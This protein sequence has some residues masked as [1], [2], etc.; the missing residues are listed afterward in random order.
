MRRLPARVARL[1]ARRLRPWLLVLASL[2]PGTPAA[3]DP[4][5]APGGGFDR[6][7]LTELQAR[8]L[9]LRLH[10]H[11]RWRALVHYERRWPLPGFTSDATFDGFYLA[12]DGRSDPRSELAATLAAFFDADAVRKDEPVQCSFPARFRWLDEELALDPGR[13]P[14]QPC[15]AYDAWRAGLGGAAISLVFPEAFMNSPASMFG[16][17]LLRVDVTPEESPRNLAAYVLDFTAATGGESGPLYLLKGLFGRYAGYFSVNPYYAKTWLYADWQNRDI[18]EYRLRLEP[19]EIDLLLMQLWELRAVTFP[20]WFLDENC[21]YRLLRLL[22]ASRPGLDLTVGFGPIVLPVDTVRAVVEEP[23]LVDR[24]HYRA[25]PATEIRSRLAGLSEAARGFARGLGRAELE[26]D[27]A[28]GA[29]LDLRERAAALSIGYD[30]LRYRF[31]AGELGEQEARSRAQRILLARSR[32]GPAP[33]GAPLFAPLAEPEVR[34]DLGHRSSRASLAG[35]VQN[36]EGFLEAR[37]RWALHDL[38]DPEGGYPRGSQVDFLDARLRW[39]PGAGKLRLEDA[40]FLDVRSLAP[41][42]DFFSPVS[43]RFELGLRT[44]LFDAAGRGLGKPRPVGRLSGGLGL[45]YELAEWS[46]AYAFA[47]ATLDGAPALENDVAAGPGAVAGLYLGPPG[48][49]W[50]G[51]LFGRVRGFVLGD[52]TLATTLG[53]EQR[54]TLHDRLALQLDLAWQRDFGHAWLEGALAWHVYF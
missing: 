9:E 44:R 25:S 48:G 6:A 47:E 11:P 33:G 20:Y 10:E 38:L 50:K 36:G 5:P 34:P 15:A 23:G 7:Y 46:S 41:R 51:H 40:V 32:L 4:P 28:A 30:Y 16:H 19:G 54:L 1:P 17:T 35:G 29:E 14:R 26:P 45:A 42:D 24:V 3:A 13:L 31:L 22:E 12:P 27:D 21:S 52:T 2:L 49:R 18:W 8:A 37:L 53:S 39:F 43:W